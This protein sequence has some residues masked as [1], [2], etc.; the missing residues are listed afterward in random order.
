MINNPLTF[1]TVNRL[2]VA[3]EANEEANDFIMYHLVR[4][5]LVDFIPI[6]KSCGV[7]EVCLLSVPNTKK[8]FDS[9]EPNISKLVKQ[10]MN[11]PNH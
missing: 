1:P 5:V 2:M 3:S 6:I 11:S 10:K 4:Y 7:A 9:Y 8:D